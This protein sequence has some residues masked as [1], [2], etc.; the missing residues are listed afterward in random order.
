MSCNYFHYV[1]QEPYIKAICKEI[2]DEIPSTSSS[3]SDRTTSPLE[4]PNLIASNIENMIV[5]LSS[6]ENQ[7]YNLEKKKQGDEEG[8]LDGAVSGSSEM[9]RRILEAKLVSGC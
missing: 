1:D 4:L 6:L 7:L 2:N 9:S 8:K 3:S 5:T